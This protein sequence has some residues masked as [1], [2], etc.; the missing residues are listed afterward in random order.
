M[1]FLHSILSFK[2]T[3]ISIVVNFVKQVLLL[4]F[5]YASVCIIG[6]CGG[7]SGLG[8]LRGIVLN[9]KLMINAVC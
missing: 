2:L 8:A 5:P 1:E 3:L 7:W 6:T 4:N 9:T